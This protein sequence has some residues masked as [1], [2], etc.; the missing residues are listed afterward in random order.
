MIRFHSIV[1]TIIRCTQQAPR[2]T[3]IT[4]RKKKI[5]KKLGEKLYA[6]A[7]M[8]NYSHFKWSSIIILKSIGWVLNLIK[9]G[10]QRKLKRK[11]NTHTH[12][13]KTCSLIDILNIQ[14][15]NFLNS[16]FIFNA[17]SFE[18]YFQLVKKYDDGRRNGKLA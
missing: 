5:N 10:N 2:T 11:K 1:P 6:H 15:I 13:S 16:S 14:I 8:N 4:K 3:T 18:Q 17:N 7:I 12:I 9:W